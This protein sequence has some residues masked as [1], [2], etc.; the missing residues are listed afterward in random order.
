M[1]APPL[2]S[3]ATSTECAIRGAVRDVPHGATGSLP[4]QNSMSARPGA[5]EGAA[6]RGTWRNFGPLHRLA[7]LP[8]SFQVSLGVRKSCS[9][10]PAEFP[11]SITNP[12][13]RQA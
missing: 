9:F 5:R 4:G 12:G 13:R 6:T 10:S 2:S 1:S 3:A 8:I 11:A 7:G